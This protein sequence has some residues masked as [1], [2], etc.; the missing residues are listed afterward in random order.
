[1]VWFVTPPEAVV[2]PVTRWP[3]SELGAVAHVLGARGDG[4]AALASHGAVGTRHKRP[5]KRVAITRATGQRS[6]G[7]CHALAPDG[8]L[9]HDRVRI[10][11]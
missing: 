1:M 8:Q 2:D 5:L 6:Q 3:L 4:D 7:H 11:G 10:D 9:L